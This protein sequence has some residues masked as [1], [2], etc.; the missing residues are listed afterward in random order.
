MILFP[1]PP[2]SLMNKEQL[3]QMLVNPTQ[4]QQIFGDRL[5]ALIQGQQGALA[6]KITGMLL[7]SLNSSELVIDDEAAL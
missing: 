6:G 5:H 3:V 7:D 1:V 4:A 2:S